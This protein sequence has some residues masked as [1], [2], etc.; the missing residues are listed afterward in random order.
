MNVP[1]CSQACEL[2][3]TAGCYAPG[4][5]A[6]SCTEI[7]ERY[8]ACGAEVNALFQCQVDGGGGVTCPPGY[9]AL[10][11][12][13][14]AEKDALQLCGACITLQDD[15][16]CDQCR[17]PSCC[18]EFLAFGT[19]PDLGDYQNCLQGC[20]TP[21][22]LTA[23]ESSFPV[24]ATAFKNAQSCSENQCPAACHGDASKPGGPNDRVAQYCTTVDGC[25]QTRE[26]CISSLGG[27]TGI[28][29]SCSEV[30]WDGLACV[31]SK[32]FTCENNVARSEECEK[33][34]NDCT[35][36]SGGF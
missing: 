27:K 10:Y 20:S 12:G 34:I 22:C 28:S 23:C 29:T 36:G 30:L 24:A 18:K 15:E 7:G 5:C 21:D 3:V 6:E 31:T 16:F 14:D 33:P 19:A 26:E 17:K 1:L 25:G 11:V 8:A 35:A 9:G 32:G 4:S 2:G 13:C